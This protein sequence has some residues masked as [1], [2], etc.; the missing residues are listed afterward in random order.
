MDVTCCVPHAYLT[1][2]P[3]RPLLPSRPACPGKPGSPGNPVSPFGPGMPRP[4]GEPS[5]PGSP[6]IIMPGSPCNTEIQT[7]TVYYTLQICQNIFFTLW[8]ASFFFFI[9][10]NH[11][12]FLGIFHLTMCNV[13]NSV[14]TGCSL[15]TSC[16]FRTNILIC[17]NSFW[18]LS[19]TCRKL[20]LSI[21][22]QFHLFGCYYIMMLVL[23]EKCWSYIWI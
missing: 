10:I 17:L 9:I 11:H 19:P 12:L 22:R 8:S 1:T 20:L 13:S 16:R 6:G 14:N 15:L 21:K 2:V 5:L 4:P 7:I 3:L 18:T 23:T